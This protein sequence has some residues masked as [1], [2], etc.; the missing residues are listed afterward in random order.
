MRDLIA[1][2]GAI[3]IGGGGGAMS[4]PKLGKISQRFYTWFY[5]YREKKIKNA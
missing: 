5:K 2:K 4:L 1:T 3:L